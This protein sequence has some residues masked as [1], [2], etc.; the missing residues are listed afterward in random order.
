MTQPDFEAP[1]LFKQILSKVTPSLTNNKTYKGITT[2]PDNS[3]DSKLENLLTSSL[4]KPTYPV[5]FSLTSPDG[6][7]T[8]LTISRLILNENSAKQAINF[9]AVQ[10]ILGRRH[11]LDLHLVNYSSGDLTLRG[12]VRE[13]GR[14]QLVSPPHYKEPHPV[15]ISFFMHAEKADTGE[16]HVLQST[17][18]SIVD[19]FCDQGVI[20]TYERLKRTTSRGQSKNSWLS[21][22]PFFEEELKALGREDNTGTVSVESNAPFTD[23]DKKTF[24][25]A[26]ETK[27]LDQIDESLILVRNICHDELNRVQEQEDP[28]NSY[29]LEPSELE[30]DVVEDDSLFFSVGMRLPFGK[31]CAE[32]FSSK[33]NR[34][35]QTPVSLK[36]PVTVLSISKKELSQLTIE[37]YGPRNFLYLREKFTVKDHNNILAI[38]QYGNNDEFF[39]NLF[40]ALH[41]ININSA[42]TSTDNTNST[43]SNSPATNEKLT[44]IL[45]LLA[46]YNL[47]AKPSNA[48]ALIGS[49]WRNRILPIFSNRKQIRRSSP[50]EP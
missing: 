20:G 4:N 40:R 35:Q 7:L 29:A 3:S 13:L 12:E 15:L 31:L 33:E 19:V 42:D 47:E 38:T 24:F 37:I 18:Q 17:A 45:S 22:G 34:S 50:I 41:K 48:A 49:F 32:F 23:E 6:A 21:L 43:K 36:L 2:T 39:R 11:T 46:D 5:S 1:R 10:N 26:W 8:L 9:Y 16:R 28:S 25:S 44:P 14:S 30:P 27:I